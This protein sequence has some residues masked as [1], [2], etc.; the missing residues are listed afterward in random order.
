MQGRAASSTPPW[1]PH[2]LATV[3]YFRAVETPPHHK[4]YSKVGRPGFEGGTSSSSK[5]S[6]ATKAEHCYRLQNTVPTVSEG[7]GAGGF[8]YPHSESK[9]ISCSSHTFQS[10]LSGG[11]F[12]CQGAQESGLCS[13]N[14]FM[15]SQEVMPIC[16]LQVRSRS[17]GCKPSLSS[18]TIV[19]T[20]QNYQFF[21]EGSQIPPFWPSRDHLA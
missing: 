13:L 19:F 15:A 14:Y 2:P 9:R 10:M 3:P 16:L 7:Q 5:P 6:I 11:I 1:S 8:C 20:L 18:R 12:R 17:E 21:L 4:L